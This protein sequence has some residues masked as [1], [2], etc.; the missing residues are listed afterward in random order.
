[1][2]KYGAAHRCG[3][4][5]DVGGEGQA[6]L[7]HVRGQQRGGERAPC[8]AATR[9]RGSVPGIFAVNGGG[10]IWVPASLVRA[11]GPARSCMAEPGSSG[12]R[13]SSAKAAVAPRRS[14]REGGAVIIIP[15]PPPPVYYICDSP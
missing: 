4:R 11:A 6:M 8:R 12:S 1:V 13:G 9:S 3:E 10:W 15:P 2:I 7:R 5:A 14:L